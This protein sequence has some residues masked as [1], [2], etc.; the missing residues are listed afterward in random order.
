MRNF[1]SSIFHIRRIQREHVLWKKETDGFRSF[2]LNNTS[3]APNIKGHL[4]LPSDI[5][6]QHFSF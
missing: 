6:V 1:P 4:L 5:G 3:L 2:V